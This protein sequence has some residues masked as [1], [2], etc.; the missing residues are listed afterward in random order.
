[1]AGEPPGRSV[2][3]FTN[4]CSHGAAPSAQIPSSVLEHV[5]PA[6]A[7]DAAT[8]PGGLSHFSSLQVGP[9]VA[10]GRGHRPCPP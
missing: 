10:G 3:S 6:W 9:E 8:A 5:P 7:E 1:M 2:V 4:G